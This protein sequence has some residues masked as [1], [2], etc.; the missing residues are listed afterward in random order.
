MQGDSVAWKTSMKYLLPPRLLVL[1]G[2]YVVALVVRLHV[3]LHSGG[4]LP[5]FLDVKP[6]NWAQEVGDWDPHVG[7]VH[8][9]ILKRPNDLQVRTRH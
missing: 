2:S 9:I 1:D 5:C 6:D 8:S 4:P 7:D 3:R